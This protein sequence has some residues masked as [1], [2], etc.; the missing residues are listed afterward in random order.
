M[1]VLKR[2]LPVE[3]MNSI[4]LFFILVWSCKSEVVAR[5]DGLASY[6]ADKFQGERTASGEL[7]DSSK[8]TAAHRDWS[9]GQEVRVIRKDDGR[10]VVVR[11]NDRG[12]FNKSRV[13][14]LSKAAARDL[15]MLHEGVLEVTLEVL[16]NEE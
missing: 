5:H 10:S 14:D 11:V 7:Y 15:G 13:I 6:Y 1:T 9:F 4:I 12:P 16:K 8:Y 3:T 2:N